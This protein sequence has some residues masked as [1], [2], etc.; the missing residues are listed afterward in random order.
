MRRHT[1]IMEWTGRSSESPEYASMEEVGHHLAALLSQCMGH[2]FE[3][4]LR[5]GSPDYL[6]RIWCL[7]GG[8]DARRQSDGSGTSVFQI[9]KPAN[10]VTRV[11]R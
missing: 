11:L 9:E 5:F 4:Y 8:H 3:H 1:D 7:E 10:N 6:A 2:V